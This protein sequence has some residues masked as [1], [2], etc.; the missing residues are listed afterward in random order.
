M[1]LI[2]AD[3]QKLGNLHVMAEQIRMLKENS[4]IWRLISLKESAEKH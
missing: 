4:V 1:R 3:I 2:E